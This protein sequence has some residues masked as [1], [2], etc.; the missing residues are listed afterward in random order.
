MLGDKNNPFLL[1]AYFQYRREPFLE[2]PSH[3]Q[4]GVA[5]TLFNLFSGYDTGGLFG[6]QGQV[7][8]GPGH[9][10][11]I[12]KQN[13]D[14][15]GVSVDH[16]MGRHD[17]KF[18]WDAQRMRVDGTEAN[19]F[20]NQLFATTSDF[21][22]FG[23]V[24]AGVY[25]LTVQ[26]GAVPADNDIAIRNLYNGLFLQDDWKLRHNLTLNLGVR[27]DY[28]SAFPHKENILPRLGFAWAVSPRTVINASW[29]VFYDH[30]R[31]G[32]ARDIP[33]FGGA[34]IT[35]NT[36]LSS[37]RLFYGDPSFVSVAVGGPCLSQTLTDAQILAM[38]ATCPQ[39]PGNPYFG[40][41][42]LNDVVAAGHA[43]IPANAVVNQG[44]V[45]SLTGFSPAQ[46][47]SA[48]SVAI[49]QPSDYFSY[50]SF[51]N[52]TSDLVRGTTLKFPIQVDSQ[53]RTPYTL[54]FHAGIQ[55][56]FSTNTALSVD[57]Y[58]KNIDHILGVRATN[59]A[60]AARLNGHVDETTDGKPI[61]E[62]YG[63]WYSGQYDGVT[64]DFHKRMSRRFSIQFSYTYSKETDNQ[65]NTSFISD[66]QA[67][68][69]G[70]Q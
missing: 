30:F 4:A 48:A 65:L 17:W 18:G 46:F 56:Q 52:L 62:T 54:G 2:Y 55:H 32:L 39:I 67:A 3:P 33:E 70:V 43:P 34:D 45:Q 13:Y 57:Y 66:D 35:G 21:Q 24:N 20:F 50:D 5:S 58:H 22:T 29:G 44:N 14:N 53:F 6:D 59:L 28:D 27:W 41:N 61:T 38:G 49:G 12:I 15:W 36:F 11:L 69:S 1:N 19:N 40:I 8:F 25:F 51:G 26:D 7:Q 10:P 16:V 47:A 42:H 63:P 64:A 60:F 9:T 31:L 23:P 37:P 68:G